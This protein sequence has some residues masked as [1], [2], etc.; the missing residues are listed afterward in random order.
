M[1]KQQQVE[2]GLV[3]ILACAELALAEPLPKEMRSRV[4]EI[5]QELVDEAVEFEELPHQEALAYLKVASMLIS[6]GLSK[7]PMMLV[8]GEEVTA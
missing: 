2:E 6:N 4:D 3:R 5:K 8:V 7:G 1:N